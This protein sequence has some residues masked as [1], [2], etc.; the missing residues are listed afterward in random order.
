MSYNSDP[1]QF[2][3]AYSPLDIAALQYLYGPS[4]TARAGNDTYSLNAAA[5]NFIWD[6][7]GVDTLSANGLSQAVTLYLEPGYWGFIGAKS[8]RI[9]APGQ[10][11][12]NFGTVIENLVGGSGNDS[13]FGNSIANAISG[14]A[15]DDTITGGAGDDSIDGGAGLDTVVFAAAF[16]QARITRNANGSIT[17][18]SALDGA[19]TLV[20]V[21]YAKFSDQTRPLFD[22]LVM[23][24]AVASTPENTPVSNVVYKA[25]AISADT[26]ALLSY[27]LLGVDAGAFNI[28]S[29]TGEVTFKAVPN[30]E[31]PADADKHNDYQITVHMSDGT[32]AID[33]SVVITVTDVAE[34]LAR[35]K[36]VDAN[37]KTD[38]ILQN[39]VYGSCYAWLVNGVAKLD[40]NGYVGWTP[41]ADWQAKATGDFNGDG[42]NDILLQN[43]KDSSCYVWELNGLK[44]LSGSG[45]VGWTP[46]VDWQVKAT[47]DFN[48][49]GR[50]DV[51]LQNVKTGSCYLWELDGVGQMKGYGYVGWGPGSDWQV[52]GTGDFNGDGESDILLQNIKTGS[53]YLWELDGAGQ[54][55]GHG[56]VG[57]GIGPDWQ[58]R[59][60]ADFNNDHKTDILLQNVG[61]GSC[62]VWELDGVSPLKGYGFVGWTPGPDWQVKGTGDFN[63][64][65]NADI[66]LQ[67]VRD[68]SCYLW[69]LNGARG[70]VS[71][72]F[73]GWT[74]GA[75]WH[76]VS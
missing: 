24:D 7:A 20:N 10:V 47:D 51:L 28:N 36:D 40:G 30:F 2:H 11:T 38:I 67:N 75:D 26:H 58:V 76:A 59:A 66:L 9:T 57:W 55:R 32:H 8:D 48:D 49:D 54:L 15:G 63:G 12:V 6:G 56:Y 71:S 41:G 27:S 3:L 69:D 25:A 72:G 22:L 70:L 62:F 17:I 4:P 52:K 34:P 61:D 64:D 53:C 23:S 68:G 46:G 43:A 33:Q 73:V 5:P 50:S 21:E 39:A 37:G 31:A 14:G 1:A 18:S 42:L 74:P 13:L 45:F 60:T 29:S 35:G 19:D 16:A 44:G 65:H